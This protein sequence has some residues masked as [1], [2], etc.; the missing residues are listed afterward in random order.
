MQFA[1]RLRAEY[2]D[3]YQ[4]GVLA[5]PDGSP[6][7][8]LEA[9]ERGAGTIVTDDL[10][11][12]NRLSDYPPLKQVAVPEGAENVET[13]IDDLTVRQLRDRLGALEV[14]IPSRAKKPELVALLRDAESAGRDVDPDQ[15]GTSGEANEGEPPAGPAS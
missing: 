7:N 8:V 4:G 14:E 3:D 9:L 13:T 6:F 2:E 1:F 5:L 15:A 10:R 11:I 12:A